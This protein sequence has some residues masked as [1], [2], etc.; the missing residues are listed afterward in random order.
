MTPEELEKRLAEIPAGS[1]MMLDPGRDP[2]TGERGPRRMMPVPGTYGCARGC[3]RSTVMPGICPTC[4]GKERMAEARREFAGALGSIPE[5]FRWAKPRAEDMAKRA[6]PLHTQNGARSPGDMA[7]RIAMSVGLAAGAERRLFWTMRGPTGCGKTSIACAA[8]TALCEAGIASWLAAP[9]PGS[10]RSERQPAAESM[11]VRIARGARFI[12]AVHLMPPQDESDNRPAMFGAAL[13]AT[14]LFLDDLGKELSARED[15]A[16]SAQ[17]AAKTREL[18]EERWNARRPT[19]I[20]TALS[21]DALNS[22][23][24]GGTFRRFAGDD[25]VKFLDWSES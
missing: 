16:A 10:R 15:T 5:A 19:V 14:V 4:G 25:Q 18:I 13:R 8:L 17:R 2:S 7:E 21:D 22:I 24:D 12:P 1:T 9:V 11:A 23:Y 3:G 6:Q 20:T